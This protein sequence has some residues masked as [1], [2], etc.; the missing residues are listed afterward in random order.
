MNVL[1][2]LRE[3]LMSACA[4]NVLGASFDA[5]QHLSTIFVSLEMSG[6]VVCQYMVL[7][8]LYQCTVWF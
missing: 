7:Q 8:F 2:V 5:F 4:R 1:E 6:V 3:V